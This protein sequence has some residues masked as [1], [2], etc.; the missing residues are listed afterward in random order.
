MCVVQLDLPKVIDGKNFD[1]VVIKQ[2]MVNH[3]TKLTPALASRQIGY[4]THQIF[5]YY[6]DEHTGDNGLCR[7]EVHVC[8]LLC[9]CIL[10][11][12]PILYGIFPGLWIPTQTCRGEE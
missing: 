8:K 11:L 1:V 3:E 7:K 6:V 12:T 9:L 4:V 10:Y 2:S 5:V